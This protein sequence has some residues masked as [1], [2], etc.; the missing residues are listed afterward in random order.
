MKRTLI[1]NFFLACIFMLSGKETYDLIIT[2]QDNKETRIG[3]KEKPVI[4]FSGSDMVISSQS[5]DLSFPVDNIKDLTY[6]NEEAGI[7]D[8]YEDSGIFIYNDTIYIMNT[9][10]PAH[11]GIYGLDGK[12]MD[13]PIK[14]DGTHSV[15][16]LTMYAPGIYII[17]VNNNSFKILKK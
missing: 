10:N 15:I 13:T 16:D 6:S 7:D 4:T 11:I 9:G 1:F 8:V 14:N 17:K 5:T 3:L 12:K 2:T